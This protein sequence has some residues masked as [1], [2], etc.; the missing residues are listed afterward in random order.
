MIKVRLH[1]SQLTL[2]ISELS[3]IVMTTATYV[4]DQPTAVA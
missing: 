1:Q 4:P 2:T 3:I